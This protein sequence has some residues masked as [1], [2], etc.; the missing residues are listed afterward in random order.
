MFRLWA[1]LSRPLNWVWGYEGTCNDARRTGQ[2]M[3]ISGGNSLVW[4]HDLRDWAVLRNLYNVHTSI[5]R[6]LS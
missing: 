5:Y 4:L 6:P 2:K 3:F 1:M